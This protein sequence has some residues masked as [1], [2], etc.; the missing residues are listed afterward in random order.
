MKKII[1]ALVAIVSMAMAIVPMSIASA[2]SV[3]IAPVHT[4]Y[5][6]PN[7]QGWLQGNTWDWTIPLTRKDPSTWAI[8]PNM[9][10]TVTISHMSVTAKAIS[11]PMYYRSC[12]REVYSIYVTATGLHPKTTYSVIYYSDPW[13]GTG[14][15]ELLRFTSVNNGRGQGSTTVSTW[16][17]IPYATDANY[18]VGGKIWLVPSSDYSGG[19]MIAWNPTN[20]LFETGLVNIP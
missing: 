12:I 11:M 7:P 9:K 3:V 6:T 14:G 4:S 18:P 8:T 16:Q 17:S 1:L 20:Y 15:R 13:N 2:Y 10:A 5:T 19:Q